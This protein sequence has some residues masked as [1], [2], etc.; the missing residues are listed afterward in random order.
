VNTRVGAQSCWSSRP[1]KL[2]KQSLPYQLDDSG[3]VDRSSFTAD[4]QSCMVSAQIVS[5]RRDPVSGRSS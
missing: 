3:G 4:S 1:I 5:S 2:R